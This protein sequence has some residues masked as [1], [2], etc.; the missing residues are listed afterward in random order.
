MPEPPDEQYPFVLLTGRGSVSQW[1]TQTRTRQSAVLRKL[2][3]AEAYVEIHPDDANRLRVKAGQPIV[4]QS[5]RA[6]IQVKVVLSRGVQH[7]HVFLPMH[8]EQVN[9]LT[10]P[11]FDP[12]SRQP[13]YKDCAVHLYPPSRPELAR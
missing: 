10:L 11:H 9:R 2:Y 13:S 12:H 4:I 8:Y 6:S 7:G 5:R 3:P 1:H